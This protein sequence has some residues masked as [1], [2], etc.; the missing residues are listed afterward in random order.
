MCA[1]SAFLVILSRLS[2]RDRGLDRQG[3][4]AMTDQDLAPLAAYKNSLGCPEC[5]VHFYCG[6][7][8]PVQALAG[9]ARRTVQYCQL[10]RL[11]VGLAAERLSEVHDMLDRHGLGPADLHHR[12]AHLAAFTDVVP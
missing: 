6:G 5:G 3:R 12:S 9:S 4:L 1:T 2:E 8:C 10:M 7:R 11:H